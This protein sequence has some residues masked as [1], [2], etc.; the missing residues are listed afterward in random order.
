MP[1]VLAN[2]LRTACPLPASRQRSQ[3]AVKPSSHSPGSQ[4]NSARRVSTGARSEFELGT[5]DEDSGDA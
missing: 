2:H 4:S 1:L 5:A 3:K